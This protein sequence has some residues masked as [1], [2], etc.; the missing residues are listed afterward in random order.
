M[1]TPLQTYNQ[2][3]KNNNLRVSRTETEYVFSESTVVYWSGVY[4]TRLWIGET[5]LFQ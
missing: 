5:V 1:A 4:D 3:E 2:V